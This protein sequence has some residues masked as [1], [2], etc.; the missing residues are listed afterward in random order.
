M[1][2][3][4]VRSW[5]NCTTPETAPNP[6]NKK[7]STR[8][9]RSSSN[10]RPTPRRSSTISIPLNKRGVLN[11]ELPEIQFR[12]GK[13][14]V[15]AHRRLPRLRKRKVQNAG[16]G[17]EAGIL[18]LGLS[19]ASPE[20][21]QAGSAGLRHWNCQVGDLLCSTKAN[22]IVIQEEGREATYQYLVSLDE[23]KKAAR[24]PVGS[25]TTT[26]CCTI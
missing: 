12:T 15:E 14:T 7:L 2:T 22:V 19:G 25:M 6:R 1:S 11:S 17:P 13:P 4:L 16:P 3:T 26:F 10:S 18:F 5:Q 20:A 9:P 8:S 24:L 23:L 21:T